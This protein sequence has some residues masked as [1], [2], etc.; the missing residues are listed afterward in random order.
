MVAKSTLDEM[1]RE[2]RRHNAQFLMVDLSQ[3]KS[4][5][6]TMKAV[7]RIGVNSDAVHDNSLFWSNGE[8]GFRFNIEPPSNR[9]VDFEYSIHNVSRE[10]WPFL[11][12]T[13]L[14][15]G[16]DGIPIFPFEVSSKALSFSDIEGNLAKLEGL[17][18]LSC[19]F[20]FDRTQVALNWFSETEDEKREFGSGMGGWTH[21][22]VDQQPVQVG[23]E[24]FVFAVAAAASDDD[25]LL[26][27]SHFQVASFSL[28]MGNSLDCIRHCYFFLEQIFAP[29]IFKS[30]KVEEALN[31]SNSFRHSLKNLFAQKNRNIVALTQRLVNIDKS[32]TEA[33]RIVKHII[34]LRGRVQ[35]AQKPESPLYW[36]NVKQ[37]DFDL[38]AKALFDICFHI[39]EELR[40]NHY[41][42]IQAE[43][44]E[45]HR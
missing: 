1:A 11:V 30:Q 34:K 26:A 15:P 21:K 23:R 14:R 36:T 45:I 12:P 32:A 5:I 9:I 29:G 42:R 17:L 8:F 19:D 10:R 7:F 18:S 3:D 22:S 27:L 33:E 39:G 31:N 38:D 16:P 41:S 40:V 25:R 37:H 28:K 43:H 2:K 6:A 13:S 4:E 44:D 20:R 24:E 35:H